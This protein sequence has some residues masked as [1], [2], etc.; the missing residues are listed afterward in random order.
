M[1]HTS[2]L[3]ILMLLP[4]AVPAEQDT[5]NRYQPG[6][7]T[8]DWLQMQSTGQSAT[9][10]PPRQTGPEA[11]RAYERYLNSFEHPIPQYYTGDEAGQM[12]R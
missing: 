4:V 10:Q 7:Q 3:I 8:R 6:E 12:R 11:A 5:E 2:L 9:Q 1:T